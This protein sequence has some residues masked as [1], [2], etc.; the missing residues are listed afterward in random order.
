MAQRTL[1]VGDIHGCLD[2]FDE[3]LEVAGYTPADRLVLAGDL[4]AKGPDSRGVIRR[5][6]QLG[7]LA[8]LGNHDEHLL[9]SRSGRKLK[10]P[11]AQVAE[12]LAPEDW[13][14]LEALPLWLD[15]PELNTLVVHAGLVPGV[16]LDHQPRHLLLNLR[17]LD[18]DGR[19]TPRIEGFTPWASKWAGPR[20]IVFGH[21]ALRG[22]QQYPLALGLDTGCVYGHALTA[23]WL[24]ERRLVSVKAHRAWHAPEP[25]HR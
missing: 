25:V 13:A 6:R 20:A 22:L 10:A 19:G 11:H 1:I 17:S 15:F 23:V 2:E 3:L 14:Y 4:V 7:A 18:D 9:A 21:D 24:P 8:V 12:S 16:A 5:A